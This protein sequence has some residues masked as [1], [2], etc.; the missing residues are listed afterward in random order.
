MKSKLLLFI[1]VWLFVS[2]SR[3]DEPLPVAEYSYSYVNQCAVPSTIMFQ[4]LSLHG[5]VFRWDFG[6]STP[7]VYSKNPVHTYI[8]E[9]IYKVTLT[10][11]GNGG[12]HSEQKWVYVVRNPQIDFNVSDTAVYVGDTIYYT[13]QTLSGVLPSTWLWNFGDGTTSTLQNTFHVYSQPGIYD[14]SL[15][16]VNACGSSFIEKKQLIK[17]NNVGN[18]PI[19]DFVANS[20]NILAGQTVN[21]TDLSINSPTSWQWTFYGATPSSSTQQ[22]PTNILY[23]TPGTYDVKLTVSNAYGSHTITKQGYIKVLQAGPTTCKIKR[24]TIKQMPFPINPPFVNV[25]F[26]ITDYNANVYLNGFNQILYNVNQ[27]MLP[28]SFYINPPYTFPTMN[29]LYKIEFYD[30]KQMN[31]FLISYV[32]FNPSN[33]SQYPTLVTLNQNG[34]NVEIELLWQ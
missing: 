29:K 20:V 14:V 32:E 23:S 12:M 5:K 33:Y 25:Y 16:A 10:A 3:N 15:T 34:M 7:P 6:D 26:K 17:V 13:A 11:Y 2:C 1:T 21:F 18:P 27:Y 28:V 30:R 9:G 4:N 22:H 8:N 24:I 31:D 19:A